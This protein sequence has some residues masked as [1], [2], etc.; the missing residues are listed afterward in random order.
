MRKWK[1]FENS[2]QWGFHISLVLRKFFWDL[3][4]SSH[5]GF[6]TS[7][8]ISISNKLF[9]YWMVPSDIV[10]WFQS[11]NK[12]PKRHMNLAKEIISEKNRLV[13]HISKPHE[14]LYQG[15]Q[16]CYKCLCLLT[17]RQLHIYKLWGKFKVAT[18]RVRLQDFNLKM[19]VYIDI[20]M[21]LQEQRKLHETLLMPK[22]IINFIV[23]YGYFPL[24]FFPTRSSVT[25]QNS[26]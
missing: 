9:K 11:Y 7:K 26:W 16:R 3:G 8:I 10:F 22:W 13:E 4:S 25:N 1:S 21:Y 20:Y 6:R 15:K 2:Q 18:K 12:M 19:C 23:P 5:L 24:F 14:Q 17:C